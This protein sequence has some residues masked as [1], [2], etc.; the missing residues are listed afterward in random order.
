MHTYIH[1]CMH[2]YIHT[3]IANHQ[4]PMSD[5]LCHA[6]HYVQGSSYVNI[7]IYAVELCFWLHFDVAGMLFSKSIIPKWPNI[8]SIFRACTLII[9]MQPD[10]FWIAQSLLPIMIGNKK[11]QYQRTH[12]I[13]TIS[14][15]AWLIHII[16]SPSVL[17]PGIIRRYYPSVSITIDL[18]PP[19][20]HIIHRLTHWFTISIND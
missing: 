18:N 14:R 4:K 17:T 10:G 6:E 8:S 20:S 1:A 11:I 16:Y 3:Y 15:C 2:A 9:L 12:F 5:T 19:K 13:L 7:Y